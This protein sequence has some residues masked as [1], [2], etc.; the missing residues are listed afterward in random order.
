VI[1]CPRLQAKRQRSYGA[2][3]TTLNN[4]V[5]KTNSNAT[6]VNELYKQAQD[7]LAKK[8]EQHRVARANA[9]HAAE[10]TVIVVRAVADSYEVLMTEKEIKNLNIRIDKFLQSVRTTGEGSIEIGDKFYIR[11]A[12]GSSLAMFKRGDG[13]WAPFDTDTVIYKITDAFMFIIEKR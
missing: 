1:L 12:D 5:M 4:N 11:Q 10:L 6:D 8:R 2:N 13:M 7:V 3:Q 9:I